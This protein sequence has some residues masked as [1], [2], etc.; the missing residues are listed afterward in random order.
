MKTQ[1]AKVARTGDKAH[2]SFVQNN[3]GGSGIILSSQLSFQAS[4]VA[5]GAVLEPTDKNAVSNHVILVG[6][7]DLEI[8]YMGH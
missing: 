8:S 1:D 6:M 5:S 3:P 2:G 7:R 4:Q